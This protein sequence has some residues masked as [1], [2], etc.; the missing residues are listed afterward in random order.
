M[1]VKKR[2][3]LLFSDNI[4]PPASKQTK[5]FVTA[6]L[7]KCEIFAT[8]TY[9]EENKSWE[10]KTDAS[11]NI[12]VSKDE[13]HLVEPLCNNLHLRFFWPRIFNLKH[14]LQVEQLRFRPYRKSVVGSN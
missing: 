5:N 7:A 3:F 6:W 9:M 4:I 12:E 2:F 10:K 8:K 1:C 13:Y 14:V 11:L